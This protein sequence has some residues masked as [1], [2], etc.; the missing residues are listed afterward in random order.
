MSLLQSWEKARGV[1]ENIR[2]QMSSLQSPCAWDVSGVVNL[3][4]ERVT[5][6]AITGRFGARCDNPRVVPLS[7]F[8]PLRRSIL[9]QAK[10]QRGKTREK[11]R[12]FL[13]NR[14]IYPNHTHTHL[15]TLFSISASAIKGTTPC[16]SRLLFPSQKAWPSWI[17]VV[18]LTLGEGETRN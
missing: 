7:P 16:L 9:I 8:P 12:D 4:S 3:A 10:R 13:A 18:P 1:T 6:D 2:S 11:N 5:D 17:R 14:R 15:D